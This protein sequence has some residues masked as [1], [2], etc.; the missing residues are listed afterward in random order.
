MGDGSLTGCDEIG[1]AFGEALA[2]NSDGV[3]KLTAVERR[4][5][6]GRGACWRCAGGPPPGVT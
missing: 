5:E 3:E 1:L 6:S 4:L 2:P